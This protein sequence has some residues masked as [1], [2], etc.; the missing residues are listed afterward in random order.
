MIPIIDLADYLAGKPGSLERTAREIRDAFSRIG[1]FVI[2]GHDVPRALVDQTFAEA[3]RLHD[4]PMS[5][6]LGMKLN[7]HNNGYM[8]MG[9]YAVW[10][11]D[12]N[13]N[14]KPDLNEAFFIRRER[15]RPTT[16]CA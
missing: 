2:T 14:D 1:F 6:K 10:T 13:N 11:S 4:L 9:R 16:R 7:D 8:A 15:A 3:K 5:D 12:V